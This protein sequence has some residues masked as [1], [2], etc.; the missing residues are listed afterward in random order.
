MST[1]EEPDV[2]RPQRQRPRL[3]RVVIDEH[4]V[5]EEHTLIEERQR[6]TLEH[7]RM[8]A[9][10]AED[11]DPHAY[12]K[13]TVR[14]IN[15]RK[16]LDTLPGSEHIVPALDEWKHWHKMSDWDARNRKLEEL[17]GKLRRKEI[18]DAE[19]QLLVIVCGPAWRAV[20]RNL[21]RYGGVD[22][23]P[24]AHGV[25]LREEASR[26]DALDRAELDE[27]VQRAASSSALS[28]TGRP[29]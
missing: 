6:K 5:I 15:E 8:A 21:R 29:L 28:A 27:V 2:D 11:V 19:V 13:A 4:R 12:G 26:V 23:D 3:R 25:R 20:A 14:L 1:I 18:T 24:R 17:V 22:L 10:Y 16:A 7:A 9:G